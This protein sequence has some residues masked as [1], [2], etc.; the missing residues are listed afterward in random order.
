LLFPV[1]EGFK[2]PSEGF[3]DGNWNVRSEV[4]TGNQVAGWY[5]YDPIASSDV[6]AGYLAGADDVTLIAV[7]IS[8]LFTGPSI[9][10]TMYH[11]M[12]HNLD[13]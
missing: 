7:A 8:E 4:D 11:H 13:S 1:T 5:T 9:P 10:I 3:L 12:K 6:T 2:E